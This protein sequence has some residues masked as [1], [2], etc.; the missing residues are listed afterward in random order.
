M[1]SSTSRTSGRR[2]VYNA[3]TGYI[4]RRF[5]ELEGQRPGKGFVMTVYRRREASSPRALD[6]VCNAAGKDCCG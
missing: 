1:S 4:N 2:T 6:G 3:I 5:E